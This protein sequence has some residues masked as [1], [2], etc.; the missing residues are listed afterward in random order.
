M[1]AGAASAVSAQEA[2]SFD[3]TKHVVVLGTGAAGLA[4][5]IGAAQSGK[6][7]TVYERAPNPGGSS[8]RSGGVIYLGGGT[9][10]QKANNFE[11]SPERVYEYLSQAMGF[12]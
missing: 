4:A 12:G 6:S 11:D 7:V 1:A 3:E 9:P 8:R 10:A 2:Q 5:A